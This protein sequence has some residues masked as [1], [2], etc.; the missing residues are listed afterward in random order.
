MLNTKKD[1]K[2]WLN[3]YGI[4]KSVINDDLTVDVN[5]NVILC[6]QKI[7]EFPFK[8]GVISG[9]FNCR[10]NKLESLKNSPNQVNGSFNCSENKLTSLDCCPEKIG[11]S[12][13]VLK[14]S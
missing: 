10:D 8:F 13:F 7:T 11:D 2:K 1:I 12:F 6:H 5:G 4:K 9:D 3:K 14:I